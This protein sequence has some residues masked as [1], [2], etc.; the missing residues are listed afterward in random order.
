M[1]PSV[2]IS[3]NIKFH[4]LYIYYIC[5]VYVCVGIYMF[6]YRITI[7]RHS[8]ALLGVQMF[9][10]IGSLHWL[11]ASFS[12]RTHCLLQWYFSLVSTIIAGM[13]DS[14]TLFTENMFTKLELHPCTY[15]LNVCFS[16]VDKRKV[17]LN[18]LI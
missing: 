1:F 6:I 2:C 13:N 8:S 18:S 9:E 4:F 10:A 11:P 7:G 5:L 14:L 17:G 16:H 15:F 3:G 12:Q